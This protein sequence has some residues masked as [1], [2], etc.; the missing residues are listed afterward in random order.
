M[1]QQIAQRRDSVPRKASVIIK[2]VRIGMNGLYTAG[3]LPPIT[4]E[5]KE[6][7]R[8]ALPAIESRLVPASRE[9]ILARITASVMHFYVSDIPKEIS[10]IMGSQWAGCLSPFPDYIIEKAF[11]EFLSENGKKKP[12]PGEVVKICNR[13]ISK[14]RAL[15]LQCDKIIDAPFH[16]VEPEQTPEEREESKLRV[17]QMLKDAGLKR[18]EGEDDNDLNT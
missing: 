1:K 14:V 5:L 3:I 10:D 16:K 4:G 9:F 18:V 13:L 12:V 8:E 11:I 7:A 6:A 2:S 15:K 17:T